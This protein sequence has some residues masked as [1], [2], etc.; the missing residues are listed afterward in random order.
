[1]FCKN[2]SKDICV[3]IFLTPHKFFLPL[4]A[5]SRNSV[6]VKRFRGYTAASHKAKAQTYKIFKNE[7]DF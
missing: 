5:E 1:M 7:K 6:R 3:K 2:V 4:P